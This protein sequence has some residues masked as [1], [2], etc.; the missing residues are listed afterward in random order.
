V[1]RRRGVE[2]PQLYLGLPS[3]GPGVVQPPRQ[4]KGFQKLSLRPS[5]S[6]RVIFTITSRDISY[7]N[8]GDSGWAVAPGCYRVMVGRSS[9]QIVRRGRFAA[10]GGRCP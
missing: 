8:S 9:R 3:P 10:G 2:V 1:G 7:W 6:K 4:L 5:Q